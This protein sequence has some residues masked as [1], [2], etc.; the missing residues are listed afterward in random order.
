MSLGSPRTP[1][2]I[3]FEKRSSQQRLLRKCRWLVDS[4]RFLASTKQ[5]YGGLFSGYRTEKREEEHAVVDVLVHVSESFKF[6]PLKAVHVN[7]RKLHAAAAI[8]LRRLQVLIGHEVNG[9][10]ERFAA[11]LLDRK[12]VL[13][14]NVRSNSC[15]DFTN[16]L[17]R[18]GFDGLYPQPNPDATAIKRGLTEEVCPWSSYLFTFKRNIDSPTHWSNNTQFRSIIWQFYDFSRDNLDL[19]EFT[20]HEVERIGASECTSWQMLLQ[21]ST[22]LSLD[23]AEGDKAPKSNLADALWELPRD[24]LSLLQTHLLRQRERYSSPQGYALTKDEW[25]LNRLN[26]L[27]QLDIFACLGGGLGSAWLAEFKQHP[28]DL[29]ELIFPH[30]DMY[31][32]MHANDTIVTIQ[33]GPVRIARIYGRQ[34]D[35]A[36]QIR[37]SLVKDGWGRKIRDRI[38]APKD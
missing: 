19:I 13:R 16:S 35:R 36:E 30:S 15:Q 28:E 32:T 7:Y 2:L 24:T 34:K 29:K 3:V 38:S 33:L 37:R 26:V 6:E 23:L 18:D 1:A 31:G 27:Q 5:V 21:Q 14:W 9:H 4:R 20:E 8:V 22:L 12:T 10:L 11:R 17:L 25:I